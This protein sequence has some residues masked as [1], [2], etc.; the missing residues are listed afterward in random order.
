MVYLVATDTMG[1]GDESMTFTSVCASVTR[2]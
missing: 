1:I 2:V